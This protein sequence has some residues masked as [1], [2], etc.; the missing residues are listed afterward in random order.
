MNNEEAKFILRA[1]RSNGADATDATFCAALEQARQD[2]ALG[3]WFA[4]EQAFDRTVSAK[5]NQVPAPAGLRESILAGGRVTAPTKFQRSWWQ[6]PA[7]LTMAASVALLLAVGVAL[8]PKRASAGATFM[9]FVAVDAQNSL[10]HH[11]G[12]G[13]KTAALQVMLSQPTTKIS[14]HLPVN[15]AALRAA[16][17]RTV[18]FNGHE[19]LEVCFQREGALFHCYIAQR[20]DFPAFIAA[21]APALTNLEGSSVATW[22]DASLL[23]TVV[24]KVG[25]STLEKIL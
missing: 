25:R 11:M 17:C 1:Y 23:Y 14:E 6:H 24:G 12:H 13:E 21:V 20:A 15:F 10:M 2:P 19:V 22:A 7:V 5:L 18:Q 9:E 16:G 4:L 8:W 3:A